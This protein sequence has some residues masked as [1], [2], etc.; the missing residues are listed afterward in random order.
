MPPILKLKK[1]DPDKE[2]EFEL[3]FLLSLSVK[4]RFQMMFNKSEE[5]RK[6]LEKSGH[7]RVNQ[8]IKRK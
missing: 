7:R 3:R 8:V 5:I 4:Q 6:L 1:D 2:R